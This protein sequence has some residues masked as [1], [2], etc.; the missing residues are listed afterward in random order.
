[1]TAAPERETPAAFLN[2]LE[3]KIQYVVLHSIQ[4]IVFWCDEAFFSPS[5]TTDFQHLSL[6]RT[7]T[8]NNETAGQ[9][10][11]EISRKLIGNSLLVH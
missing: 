9:C 6:V 3:K 1:M 5:R 8:Q 7:V 2:S 10:N 11:E 4:K